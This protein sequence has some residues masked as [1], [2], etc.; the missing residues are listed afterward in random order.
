M[1]IEL[2]KL[3][4]GNYYEDVAY[5]SSSRFKEYMACPLRQQAIDF[6]SGIGRSPQ[7]PSC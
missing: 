1:E 4:E 3:T 6:D 7:M 5:M 2:P